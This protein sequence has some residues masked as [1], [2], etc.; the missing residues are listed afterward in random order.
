MKNQLLKRLEL[1]PYLRPYRLRFFFWALAQVF[2]IAGFGAAQAVW[3]LQVSRR[4]SSA[5]KPWASPC[6]KSL[7]AAR[8]APPAWPVSG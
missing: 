2:L 6:S 1:L 7:V 3:P 4:L 8:R 5:A